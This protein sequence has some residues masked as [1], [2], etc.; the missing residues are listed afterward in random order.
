MMK[1]ASL[2]MLRL[3][4]P[5]YS[6]DISPNDFF[7]YG[8]VKERLK[9]FHFTSREDLVSKVNEII[10]N[11]DKSIWSSVFDD[12]IQRLRIVIDNNGDY[13]QIF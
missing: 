6:P 3:P 4:H 10:E 7:L 12:W 2:N 13:M 5:A 11:I 9:G 1:I 8:Y